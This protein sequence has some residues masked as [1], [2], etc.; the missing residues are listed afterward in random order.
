MHE[1]LKHFVFARQETKAPAKDY[2][3]MTL[4]RDKLYDRKHKRK[5]TSKQ[6]EFRI[7]H[8]GLTSS[9]LRRDL[10]LKEDK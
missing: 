9:S 2:Y 6:T 5:I 7:R 8:I 1:C 4:L 10:V 3:C